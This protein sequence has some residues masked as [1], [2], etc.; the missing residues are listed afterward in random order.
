ML[1]SLHKRLRVDAA[2]R[3]MKFYEALQSAVEGYLSNGTVRPDYAVPKALRPYI[4][5]LI[6]ILASDDEIAIN[7]ATTV[8]DALRR[9]KAP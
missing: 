6:Q 5:V 2:N 8:L 1:P 9:R 3:G 7:A 4:E